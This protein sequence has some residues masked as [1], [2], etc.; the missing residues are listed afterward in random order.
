VQVHSL[1]N[2]VRPDRQ[3]LLFSATLPRKIESLVAEALSNPVRISVGLLGA[4]NADVS[5]RVEIMKGECYVSSPLPRFKPTVHKCH[6][7]GT[8]CCECP[9]AAGPGIAPVICVVSNGPLMGLQMPLSRLF[10][11]CNLGCW[12]QL[13][14]QESVANVFDGFLPP[15]LLCVQTM[16]LS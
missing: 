11:G 12:W 9:S 6:A 16:V 8:D 3:T 13:V 5:Q 14:Q 10:P 7:A 15:A 2:V 1:L 4:A